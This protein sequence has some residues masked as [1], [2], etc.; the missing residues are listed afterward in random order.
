MISGSSMAKK[1]RRALAPSMIGGLDDL[2]RDGQ[3]AG[4]V[5]Q[6]AHAVDP[7]KPMNMSE[8]SAVFGLL[9]QATGLAIRTASGSR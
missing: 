4:Q 8:G 3:Q 6:Q 1:R 7:G 9:S 2:R 5:D